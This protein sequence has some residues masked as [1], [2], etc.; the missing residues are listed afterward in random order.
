ML[1]FSL[2]GW[3]QLHRVA[4]DPKP[5]PTDYPLLELLTPEPEAG[6]PPPRPV[7]L[8]QKIRGTLYS[9]GGFGLVLVVAGGVA[10]FGGKKSPE[11]A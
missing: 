1:A 10:C 3:V 9:V 8:A 2:M 4:T 11:E 5:D 6:S 7:E